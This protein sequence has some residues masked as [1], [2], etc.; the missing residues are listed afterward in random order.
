MD[1]ANLKKI[2]TMTEE[3]ENSLGSQRSEFMEML[4]QVE[5]DLMAYISSLEY[6]SSQRDDVFQ[7]V[8][9]TMWERFDTYDPSFAFA[10]WGRG[11]ARNKLMQRWDRVKKDKKHMLFSSVA[12]EAIDSAYPNSEKCESNKEERIEILEKCLEHV[13]EDRRDLLRWKYEHGYSLNKIADMYN[14]KVDTISKVIRRLRKSLLECIVEKE[15][16]YCE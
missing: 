13:P 4:L 11:I 2:T 3:D 15:A 16:F 8:V 10:A 7:E 12:I 5:F 1:H 14:K 6:E 9:I